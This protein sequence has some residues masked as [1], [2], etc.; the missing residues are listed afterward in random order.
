M[1]LRVLGYDSLCRSSKEPQAVLFYAVK[2]SFKCQF[3]RQEKGRLVMGLPGN[4][5]LSPPDYPLKQ[6]PKTQLPESVVCFV[7]QDH[8]TLAFPQM[9]LQKFFVASL[10][11]AIYIPISL[12]VGWQMAWSALCGL[13]RE[14]R[15]GRGVV[16]RREPVKTRINFTLNSD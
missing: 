16:K 14:R 8:K 9:N 7:A 12:V 3:P 2:C 6:H 13:S 15:L 1:A 10:R 5:K 11:F 4:N